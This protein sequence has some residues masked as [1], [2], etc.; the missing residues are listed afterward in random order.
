MWLPAYAVWRWIWILG[1]LLCVACNQ[2]DPGPSVADLIQRQQQRDRDTATSSKSPQERLRLAQ[3]Y[4]A[5][6]N[7][8]NAQALLRPLLISQPADPQV[9]LLAAKCAN[10]TGQRSDAYQLLESID[11]TNTQVLADALWL[12]AHWLAEEDQYDAA[13]QKL[14]RLLD[15]QLYTNRVHRRLAQWLNF[16]GLRHQAAK[17]LR[18]LAKNGDISEIELFAMNTYSDPFIDE[19][20]SRQHV[21]VGFSAAALANA[22]VQRLEGKLESS[23]ALVEQLATAFPRSTPIAAFRG[24]IYAELQNDEKLREWI[25]ALPP[26]MDR[27][28]EYW[29]ALGNWMQRTGKH[30]EAVRCF[31]EAV[32]RD[33]TDRFSYLALAR[34]LT[35]LD[36]QRLAEL[37]MQRYM[38]LEEAAAIARKIGRA[39]GTYQDL[40]QMA[41]IL[42]Q[43]NRPWEA[44]GWRS[45]ARSATEAEGSPS[46]ASQL[47]GQSLVATTVAKNR[48]LTLGMDLS[49]WPLPTFE[50][51][52]VIQDTP[53]DTAEAATTSRRIALQDVARDVHLTFQYDNGDDLNDQSTLLHQMT[54]G[55]IGVIDFDRDGWPDLYFTQAG[56]KAFHSDGSKPN[57]LFRNIDGRH[58]QDV[59]RSTHTDD[60]GYGQGIAVADLNQDGFSDLVIANIGPNVLYLNN[61]DGTFARKS[62]GAADAPGDWTTSI[63]CGDLSGDGLPEILEVNYVDDGTAMTIACTPQRDICN[64]SVFRPAGDHVWKITADGTIVSWDG[65][66]DMA[67]KPNYGFAA[68][69]A[70]FDA[71]A[72][73]DVFIAN[74]TGYNHFWASQRDDRQSEAVLSEVAHVLGCSSGLL[75]QQQGCMG[76]AYGDFDRN[77]HLDLH[78]T[79]FWDQPA[80]LYMQ[81]SSGLFVNSSVSRGLYEHSQATVGW[82]TQ[83]ADFDR[84][85]WLDL[86]ILNGHLMDYRQRG[87]PYQMRPQ[88]FI[89]DANGFRLHV[90]EAGS[91]D[92]YWM[93]PTLGRS[94]AILDWNVDGKPDL[95]AGHLDLPA[96]LLQNNT[97]SENYIQ[98]E[99]MGVTSERDA[100]GAKL[101]VTCGDES[102]ISFVVGGHGFLCSNEQVVDFGINANRKIDQLKVSWPS[103]TEQIFSGLVANNRYMIVEG[104]S[105]PYLRK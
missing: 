64:P 82:G 78:V 94:L 32:L 91:G 23:R 16:Q 100:V 19:S 34:S 42:D 47:D 35:V 99:L 2:K 38:L 4:F 105:N 58:F 90:S 10:A 88:L 28:P 50:Q 84:N 80:D 8:V 93:T 33:E 75:G 7:A 1:C 97:P 26:G 60:E 69:I 52:T 45:I 86:A 79:N 59:T 102:W 56:G 83:A 44:M 43:L 96:A 54:G 40:M 5:N 92:D 68:V 41:K 9:L 48:F 70:N 18:E 101:T 61:G 30:R 71:I 66:Q 77:G 22:K 39:P 49:Q 36:N 15:L 72:G 73:N 12:S 31:A 11:D 87:R 3:Q 74:D 63:A 21:R 29:S 62:L 67:G 37:A 65:C 51:S 13:Q 53:P 89:G 85:G 24:R 6:D 46:K 98:F 81:N 27:E 95:A 57:Q 14:Y 25:A 103:G 55:G 17:H 104:E 76:V 20:Q